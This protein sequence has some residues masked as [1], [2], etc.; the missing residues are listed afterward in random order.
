M[1]SNDQ[2]ADI[3]TKALPKPSFEKGKRML[4]MADVRDLSLREDVEK[5]KLQVSEPNQN[6]KGSSSKSQ[7]AGRDPQHAKGK[8]K[9]SGDAEHSRG[10]TRI[11]RKLNESKGL[12]KQKDARTLDIK[13]EVTREECSGS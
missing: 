6:P 12:G 1:Q 3:L 5:C 2:A 4:G 9:H 13:P 8:E 10:G 7:H 11:M